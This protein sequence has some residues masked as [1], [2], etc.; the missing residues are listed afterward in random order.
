MLLNTYLPEYYTYTI[1]K[2]KIM[3]GWSRIFAYYNY[4]YKHFIPPG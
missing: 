4:F 1:V 2:F 3:P